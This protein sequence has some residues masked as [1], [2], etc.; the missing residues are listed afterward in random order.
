M[1]DQLV[2][3]AILTLHVEVCL[4]SSWAPNNTSL[5]F[6]AG[7][8]I[9]NPL[10]VSQEVLWQSGEAN[11]FIYRCPLLTYTPGGNLLIVAEGRKG[12]R[13]A[14]PK[15][16][17]TRR[18]IDGG[19]EWQTESFIHDDSFGGMED[20][21]GAV[22]VD[23][24][25]KEIYI[26]YI[27]CAHPDSC[28]SKDVPS[29]M[30]VKS[31]DDGISW[32]PSVNV[33]AIAGPRNFAPGPG[34]G[35]Q[36]KYPPHVGRLIVCGHGGTLE[37]NGNF[38]LLSDDHG[39]TW[40]WGA[41]MFPIPA[42]VGNQ[43]GDFVPDECQPIELSN[44]S[45]ILNSRNQYHFHCN[46]RIVTMSHDGMETFDLMSIRLD[47]TLVESAVSASLLS[48]L[49]VVFFS[50]PASETSRVN[51]T[52]RWSYD[53]GATW[54]GALPLWD[55][56]SAYSCMTAFPKSVGFAEQKYVFLAFEKGVKSYTES[57]EFVKI[58]LDGT[59]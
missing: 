29:L 44:G 52:V 43:K 21:L 22:L 57:I 1:K 35:I 25:T 27:D 47:S 36:K 13:D 7:V 28:S 42:N 31:K 33:T 16:I 41:E 9:V 30:Y 54:A 2:F 26:F 56:A 55:Y 34:Y 14:D 49:G 32:E 5:K 10:V 23:D 24:I 50:N 53:E 17:A 38:C 4:C 58:S 8:P 40:R 11:V 46:C 12:G 15:F 37:V 6:D 48:H 59:L 45:V 18:S 51:M 19:H 39:K 3:L 20:N